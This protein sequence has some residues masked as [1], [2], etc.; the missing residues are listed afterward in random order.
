VIRRAGDVNPPVTVRARVARAASGTHRSVTGALPERYLP[1]DI[2]RSPWDVFSDPFGLG[3]DDSWG[4]EMSQIDRPRDVS[5]IPGGDCPRSPDEINGG[6]TPREVVGDS[7]SGQKSGWIRL[8]LISGS[9]PFSATQIGGSRLGQ[10]WSRRGG[11]DALQSESSL[12][13]L[14]SPNPLKSNH[15]RKTR[16]GD[17]DGETV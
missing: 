15:Y 14:Q 4:I 2:D 13:S 11:A 8:R 10:F 17:W 1:I 16:G 5:P 6:D 7:T 9:K 3:T 12:H